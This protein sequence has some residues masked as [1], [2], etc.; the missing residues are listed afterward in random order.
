M[1]S[2]NDSRLVVALS[3]LSFSMSFLFSHRTSPALIN[4]SLYDLLHM[5]SADK[6]VSLNSKT[7]KFSLK[8]Q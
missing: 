3:E 2:Q 7:I 6:M 4:R 5:L 1:H 8:I